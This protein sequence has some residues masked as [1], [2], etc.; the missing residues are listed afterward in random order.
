M[1]MRQRLVFLICGMVLAGPAAA[2]IAEVLEQQRQHGF[3]SPAQAVDELKKE[4]AEL[5][6]APLPLRMRYHDALASLYIGLEQPALLKAELAELDRM[7]VAEQCQ[8]CAHYKLVREAH[9]AT[10]MQD[11]A[12]TRAVLLQLEP[13]SATDPDLRQAIYYARASSYE[14]LGNHVRAIEE[15]IQ[16]A[17]LA[18]GARNPAAQ[19]R[20]LN[21][22]MLSNIGR[23][24]LPRAVA[25]AD[26]AYALAERIGYVYMMAYIRGNQGWIYSLT[27]APDKQLRMLNE[28]LAITRAHPGMHDSELI[29][30]VNLAEYHI[31]RKDYRQGATLA[32]QAMTLADGQN[33]PTAKGVVMV[34]LARAQ[35]E[36]GEP[37]KGIDTIDQ[38]VAL[39]TQAGAKGYL[40][41]AM[42]AQALV[43]ERAG[44]HAQALAALR[45]VIALKEEA[46]LR[47]REKAVSE[48]QEKF[49]A[50]RKDHEIE[51]LSLENGRRQAEVAA[52]TWQQRLW[53]MAAVALAL[54]GV[55]LIQ[56]VT[57]TR[58]RNRLLEDSNAL[59][60]DQSVHDPL[61]G[62]YNRRHCVALMSQQEATRA[63][64]SR[65]RSYSAS[66]G[67]MLL[68]V[69]HFKHINDS[70]GHYAG[71]EVL[72]EI[73]RRLQALVR[74][75]D[76]V[77]R[78]G[79]EEFVLV[80]PGTS[81]DGMTVLA[82]RVL[83]VIGDTPFKADGRTVDVTV[84]L[85]C[86][87]YPLLADLPWQDSLKV[88]DLAMY[89]AKHGGRNRAICLTHVDPATPP[90]LL[91][92][93]LAAAEETGHVKLRTILGPAES[94]PE[95][96]PEPLAQ[97]T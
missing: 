90:E 91:T 69:D 70:C 6:A 13:L 18:I 22:M 72:V 23:R 68:D 14:S 86:V 87:A 38:A 44:R 73:A 53:A 65:D 46:T 29:N 43:Y 61:T 30:L 8:P 40:I 96:A 58:R 20:A 34:S 93:D 94:A 79:G 83:K 47:D 78:W 76:V 56:L 95:I 66:V 57:R 67:L 7:A 52:R 75:H 85:G 55:L 15:G 88:A 63:G 71:D 50:E 2:G 21:M 45:K 59:L 32:Q 35:M 28:A 37:D 12:A 25:M 39:L 97:H 89:L 31:G 60:S 51:R 19:V 36:L 24:D 77:V 11:L 84:S 27:G 16:A 4:A 74:Q 48:A 81:A 26:E 41:D 9:R 3:S 5:A 92:G 54:G 1:F 17:Q 10:R 49:S 42:D 64:R 62:A 33:K 80:L 82:E